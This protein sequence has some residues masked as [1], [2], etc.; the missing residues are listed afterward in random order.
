MQKNV[1]LLKFMIPSLIGIFMFLFPLNIDGETTIPVAF[2]SG[3]INDTLGIDNIIL[4]VVIIICISSILT[5]VFSWIHKPKSEF[6]SSIFTMNPLWVVIR[7]IGAIFAV[8]A[9]FTLGPEAINSDVT[10]GMLL[11]DLLPTL[12]T[13]FLF[14]GLLLPLLLNYG[15]LEF[16]GSIFAKV[17]RP[18][19]TLPGRSTVDNLASWVGDGTVGVLLT[20]KQY[21]DG[22]YSE[23]EASVIATTFSV[24]SITFSIVVLE[25]I[26]LMDYFGWFYITIIIAGIIAAL[27]MPRIPPLSM[28]KDNYHGEVQALDETIPKGY[29]PFSWGYRKALQRAEKAAG[30]GG[31]VKDGLKTIGDMWFAVL[32]IVMAIGTFGTMLAEYTPLFTWIGAPFVPILELMGIPEAAAASE[33]IFIGFTDM[34]LPSIL[35]EGVSSDMT[36]FIIGT[37]S[38]TQLI[39]LSEV[40]GVIL[41]SKIPV[42]I[43]KL[44]VIFLL[45]TAI[46]LPIITVIAN[47][48]F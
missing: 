10:G 7:L 23:R 26:G 47:F 38:I 13:V 14:A 29:N 1:T 11:N 19:F 8:M 45:R 41:G 28:I 39:Y 35:I 12:L 25:M 48:I 9:Y 32:P 18:L 43:G 31:F 42:G 16:I 30:F 27:I 6:L 4:I 20:S 21:E 5:I 15:L 22:Y 33:T 44:L 46:T 36:R 34:F 3:L 24:V 2:L 17:M 40:G 37:L